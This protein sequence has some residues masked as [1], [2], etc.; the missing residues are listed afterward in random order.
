M[1]VCITFK[2]I[3]VAIDADDDQLQIIQELAPKVVERLMI[4]D[5][6]MMNF[7]SYYGK[8][9][10]GPLHKNFTTIVGPNGSGKSNLIECLLFVFGKRAKKMRVA[11]NIGDLIHNSSEHTDCCLAYVEINFQYIVDFTDDE[12]NYEVISGSEFSVR[13]EIKRSHPGDKK[14]TSS[15]YI[16]NDKK[17][18][19]EVEEF[20][21]VDHQI[22]L[23][24][25]RFLILQGEVESIS[26]MP[27]KAGNPNE[28]GLLEYLED[29]IGSSKY[30]EQVDQLKIDLEK[31]REEKL[32]K[33]NV[34]SGIKSSISA[35]HNEKEEVITFLRHETKYFKLLLLKDY[36]SFGKIKLTMET[37]EKAREE[38][39]YDLSTFSLKR[40]PRS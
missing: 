9:K 37:S 25:D 7:K 33:Q 6:T 24:H 34:V 12:D 32:E 16:N 30:T 19:T 1:E 4:R 5:I 23:D 35:M 22:D 11:T 38:V 18:F 14:A 15:Y 39:I 40:R 20:L 10:I 31:R 2:F 29:I 17:T 3:I 13:R 27:A 8:R 26:M 36:A 21:K 28:T